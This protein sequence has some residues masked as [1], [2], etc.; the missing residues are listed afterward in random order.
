M[1]T[2]ICLLAFVLAGC[3]TT[4]ST[5][6]IRVTGYGST[7]D[8]AKQDAFVKAT[9]I[10]VGTIIVSER[11]STIKELTKDDIIAYSSGFV[12]DYKV[13]SEQKQGNGVRVV[14]DV[15]I[16]PSKISQR[17]LAKSG[18]Y[19]N[20]NGERHSTQY[21]TILKEKANGDRILNNI[22]DDYPR[23]AYTLEQYKYSIK[24]DGYRNL[25][26]NIPYKMSWNSNYLDSFKTVL[27][28][29]EDNPYNYTGEPDIFIQNAFVRFAAN[30]YRFKDKVR[31]E[32]IKFR[33]NNYPPRINVVVKDNS[34]NVIVS[35]C[36]FPGYYNNGGIA[37]EQFTVN[38]NLIINA[39]ASNTSNIELE[40]SRSISVKDI[41]SI[42]LQ[43]I[44]HQ[45][46][47]R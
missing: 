5:G 30:S 38:N 14:L 20:F 17:V 15:S 44:S 8:A 21:Q 19:Q 35:Q 23:R 18:G 3:A 46:C 41:G 39:F 7:S 40:L 13:V 47:K 28:L 33:I 34:N 43:I 11:E 16:S 42:Q 25:S 4:Q 26:L 36:Y 10:H 45:E 29:L 32:Q 31:V 9:E 1:R 37:L 6:Y 24:V 22:M 12:D 27:K 2:L